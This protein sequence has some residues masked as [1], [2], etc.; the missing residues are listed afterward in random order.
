MAPSNVYVPQTLYAAGAPPAYQALDV[1]GLMASSPEE[2]V[3][4]VDVDTSMVHKYV[5]FI[6]SLNL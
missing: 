3:A 2:K 5:I 1:T 4:P 6:E